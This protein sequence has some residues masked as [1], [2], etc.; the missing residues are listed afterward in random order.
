MLGRQR[1]DPK[2]P[3]GFILPCQPSLALV[4]PRGPRWIHE[5]K[6]DGYRLIARKRGG[7]VR[8][9]S[10]HGADFSET[11]GR[12]HAAVAS[13]PVETA[14]LDGEAVALRADGYTD[15]S[16]L[17]T[18]AG[19]RDAALIAFDA[20]EIDGI[21]LRD[22]PVEERRAR[23]RALVGEGRDG[24]LFSEDLEA[25]GALV[26]EQVAAL[27]LEGIVSKKLGSRYRSGSSRLW[28][29]TKLKGYAST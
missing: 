15:L 13:L 8:L 14:T 26:F 1:S 27:G 3:P 18:R 12:I 20:L 11:F 17:R 19:A 22:Q 4:P 9:W 23:L 7:I 2:R 10:R 28:L 5:V 16:R 25:E 21:D 29:K 6:W 24:L